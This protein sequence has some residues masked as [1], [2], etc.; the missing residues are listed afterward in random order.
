MPVGTPVH[1]AITGFVKEIGSD[2]LYGDYIV[3]ENDSGYIVKYAS[4]SNIS[5]IPES[6]VHQGETVGY[7][8][9]CGSEPASLHMELLVNGEYYNPLFYTANIQPETD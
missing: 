1:S 9:S 2:P 8:G 3:I 7:S 4:M 5:A 6:L